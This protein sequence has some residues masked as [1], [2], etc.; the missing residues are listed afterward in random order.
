[1][2]IIT[3]EVAKEL[4]TACGQSKAHPGMDILEAV[5]LASICVPALWRWCYRL[6][7]VVV[8]LWSG[9]YDAYIAFLLFFR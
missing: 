1:M 4:S 9:A 7:G 8:V 5:S 6:L 2:H 3:S